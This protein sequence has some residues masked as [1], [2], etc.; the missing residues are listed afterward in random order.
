VIFYIWGD[1]HVRSLLRCRHAQIY[2]HWD[3]QGGRMFHNNF[4]PCVE[5][6]LATG[7]W[8]ER[9]NLL[10]TRESLY[11][12]TDP[13]WMVEHLRDDLALQLS[14]FKAGQIA[15]LDEP[16]VAQLAARLGCP[17]DATDAE[18]RRQQAAQLLDRY[19]LQATRYVLGK[20]RDCAAQN[21][22]KLLV[23]LFDPYR[24]LPE[25]CRQDTRYDQE[26]VDYL[27]AERFH[28]FDMNVVH[29]RDWRASGLPYDQYVRQFFI[30]HYNP[31]G[32][33][34]FAYAIKDTVVQWLDPKPIPYRQLDPHTLDFRGYLEAYR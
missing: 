18:P 3:H 4:W 31:R 10:P 32:N 9:D 7:G 15:D 6:D 25:L 8:V 2:P 22:R 11:R 12:M 19:A 1:D 14:V 17:W 26:I 20:L 23:V 13:E 29:A 21:E 30:G 16:R 33:H 34:F 24:V 5:L 27:A 28:Y